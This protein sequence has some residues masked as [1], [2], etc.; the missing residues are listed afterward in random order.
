VS[1]RNRRNALQKAIY[2][3]VANHTHRPLGWM[4]FSKA[5]RRLDFDFS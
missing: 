5:T 4:A 2:Q 3:E 1:R